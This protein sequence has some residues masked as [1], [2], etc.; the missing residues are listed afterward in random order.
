MTDRDDIPLGTTYAKDGLVVRH[1]RVDGFWYE[2][3]YD[4]TGG[5]LSYKDSQGWG[6]LPSDVDA[7]DTK[8]K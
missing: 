2:I 1:K 6:N 8:E 5:E 4:K 7:D 3:T